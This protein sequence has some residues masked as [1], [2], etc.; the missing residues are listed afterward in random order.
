MTCVAAREPNPQWLEAGQRTSQH[1]DIIASLAL[2]CSPVVTRTT[3]HLDDDIF[4]A[5][6]S[7]A[8]AQGKGL[9]RVISDLARQGLKP[10]PRFH[11]DAQGFPVVE[12]SPDAPLVTPEAIREALDEGW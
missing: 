10:G 3:L 12:V 11:L 5:A 6:K 1:L 2:P 8:A 7:L 9:G 4:R